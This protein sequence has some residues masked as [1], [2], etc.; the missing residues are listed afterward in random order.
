VFGAK[1]VGSESRV[2][3][4]AVQDEPPPATG[5]TFAGTEA[6]GAAGSVAWRD[7]VASSLSPA[8]QS[9]APGPLEVQ[10]TFRGNRSNWHQDWK[11]T[12]DGLA[13]VLGFEP[14]GRHADDS[15][16]TRLALHRMAD[17]SLGPRT[18][19]GVWWRPALS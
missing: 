8:T 10:I 7:R 16:I 11:P 4:G 3:A 19:I 5:W 9:A 17:R 13:A 2:R 18:H 6:A 15:R 12:I 1:G 14:N